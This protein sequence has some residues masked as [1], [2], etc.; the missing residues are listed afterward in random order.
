MQYIDCDRVYNTIS[1]TNAPSATVCE[2][3]VF[4]IHT[5]LSSGTWLKR[6]GDV[7]DPAS[8]QYAP[9]NNPAVCVCI[10][11]AQPGE[12][13]A[14]E[15]LDIVPDDVGYTCLATFNPLLPRI[16]PEYADTPLKEDVI[17]TVRI[18]DGAIF[19]SDG[20]TLKAKPMLGLMGTPAPGIDQSNEIASCF[21]GNMDIQE[22]GAGATVY[23]PVQVPGA[24]LHVGDAHA[25]QGDGELATAGGIECRSTVTLRVKRMKKPG[26]MRSVRI[27]DSR[28]FM[29]TSFAPSCELAFVEASQEMLDAMADLGI[30]RNEAFLLLAQVMEARCTQYVNPMRSYICKVPK[31]LLTQAANCIRQ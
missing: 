16:M 30:P 13:L 11:G 5:E 15:I 6:C 24:L 21:G 27:E 9:Y 18:E 25:I 19:F 26:S 8:D 4:K 17:R 7:Y 12:M 23:L 31:Q 1:A 3:E 28:Y 20:V 2:G 14:V 29:T 22:V 10:D